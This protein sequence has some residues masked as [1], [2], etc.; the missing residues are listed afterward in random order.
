GPLPVRPHRLRRAETPLEVEDCAIADQQTRAC[1]H[2]AEP[3]FVL[4]ERRSPATRARCDCRLTKPLVE[5][6]RAELRFVAWKERMFAELGA[7]VARVC[8]CDHFARIAARAEDAFEEL[9][10]VEQ[11][12]RAD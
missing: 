11:V 3:E 8:V 7:K 4:L 12:G 2:F 5:P 6:D 1:G 10:E 9:V